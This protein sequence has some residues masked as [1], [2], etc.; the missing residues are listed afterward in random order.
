MIRGLVVLCVATAL[1]CACNPRNPAALR[2]P[3]PSP[4]RHTGCGPWL[5]ITGY[6]TAKHP[7]RFVQ[8][9]NNRKQYDLVAHSYESTGAQCSAI[10]TFFTVHVTFFGNDG[11]RLIAVAPQAIVDEAA[12]TITLTGRVH[13]KTDSGMTLDCDRLTYDQRAQMVHGEG[14]VVMMNAH[15][16]RAT[17]NRVDSDVT[18]TRA[19]MR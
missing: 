9:Q 15:G 4:G 12:N 17:G 13:A 2:S 18:L 14:H 6:G 10:A 5:H 16:A 11:T 7:L 19:E 8:Q 3:S 1:L